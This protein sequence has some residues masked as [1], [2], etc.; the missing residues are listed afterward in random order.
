MSSMIHGSISGQWDGRFE[1]PR[2]ST[3]CTQKQHKYPC[4][5]ISLGNYKTP[6]CLFSFAILHRH[7]DERTTTV[8]D[9]N[10]QL[11]EMSTFL[12][13]SG[14]SVVIFQ[15]SLCHFPHH[16]PM[17]PALQGCW[18]DFCSPGSRKCQDFETIIFI[19]SFRNGKKVICLRCFTHC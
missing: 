2:G 11:S 12:N 16:L 10:V 3:E 15:Q 13:V 1:S 4:L 19:F 14:S 9:G 7:F 8:H 6:K 18:C 5:W 17:A